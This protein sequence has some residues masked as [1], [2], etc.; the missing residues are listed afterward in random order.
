MALL[1]KEGHKV[2]VG[3]DFL[4]LGGLAGQWSEAGVGEGDVRE[5]G[6]GLWQGEGGGRMGLLGRVR[7]H[8]VAAGLYKLYNK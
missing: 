4:S 3:H 7:V 1:A 6:W 5:D 2:V 8:L